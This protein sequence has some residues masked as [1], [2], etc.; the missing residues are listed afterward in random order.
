MSR[1]VNIH[2]HSNA[3]NKNLGC[4]WMWRA[5]VGASALKPL[6]L[7]GLFL[8]KHTRHSQ[9]TPVN[10]SSQALGF[11]PC[12]SNIQDCKRY[13]V[14]LLLGQAAEHERECPVSLTSFSPQTASSM[15]CLV[16][17]SCL[18]HGAEHD[19]GDRKYTRICSVL[20]HEGCKNNHFFCNK[21]LISSSVNQWVL[22]KKSISGPAV[23]L[24]EGNKVIC[25]NF[26]TC[27][28]LHL[29]CRRSWKIALIFQDC[30]VYMASAHAATWVPSRTGDFCSEMLLRQLVCLAVTAAWPWQS[31]TK[32]HSSAQISWR[33]LLMSWQLAGGGWSLQKGSYPWWAW[34]KERNT[35]V[36]LHSKYLHSS[37]SSEIW[38][39]SCQ[40]WEQHK[41]HQLPTQGVHSPPVLLYNDHV[42][43]KIKVSCP[44]SSVLFLQRSNTMLIVQ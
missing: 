5:P 19:V 33:L 14:G 31:G 18:T 41:A 40:A 29:A 27:T 9:P 16:Q 30:A 8:G 1:S 43:F 39:R 36:K 23:A 6:C 10:A 32:Q 4:L 38:N 22:F 35:V 37:H 15:L 21:R 20:V 12:P 13:T 25:L 26:S 3:S 17:C 34:G 2:S 24:I 11:V 28:T 7:P 42:N 44:N